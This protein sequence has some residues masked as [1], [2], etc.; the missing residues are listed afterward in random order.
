MSQESSDAG[1]ALMPRES[2]R[3]IQQNNSQSRFLLLDVRSPREHE[4]GHI[5]GSANL[6]FHS[7]D[8][9]QELDRL[10]RE[11]IYLVYCLVGVRSRKTLAAMKSLGFKEVYEIQGGIRA[12]HLE[13]LPVVRDKV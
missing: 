10:E 5:E 6:D 3:L 9:M 1:R 12:W 2:L 11:K 4:E 7:P 13:G 8:F